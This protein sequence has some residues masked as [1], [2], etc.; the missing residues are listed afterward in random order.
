MKWRRSRSNWDCVY[1]PTS[2]KRDVGVFDR[3]GMVRMFEEEEREMGG[4]GAARRCWVFKE[5]IKRTMDQS[6]PI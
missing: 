3:Y 4:V 5:G 6:H 2:L 1:T